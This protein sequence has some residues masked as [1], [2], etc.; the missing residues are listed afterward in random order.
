MKKFIIVALIISFS[1][2]GSLVSDTEKTN[3]LVANVEET[4]SIPIHPPVG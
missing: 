3:S 1:S 2:I 4:N